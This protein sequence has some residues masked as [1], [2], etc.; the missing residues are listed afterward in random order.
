[1]HM[2]MV[3]LVTQALPVT[4]VV[5]AVFHHHNADKVQPVVVSMNEVSVD[6]RHFNAQLSFQAGMH[7]LGQY[8][9]LSDGPFSHVVA[10]CTRTL[11]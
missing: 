1:M 6:T 11:Q 3:D 10:G 7:C 9:V 5:Y 4:Q 2:S 8:H